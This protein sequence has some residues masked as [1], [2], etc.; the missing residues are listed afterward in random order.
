M[1]ADAF[2][3][4]WVQR[5]G[6][7]RRVLTDRGANFIKALEKGCATVIGCRHIQTSPYHPEGNGTCEAF[8]KYL[9]QTLPKIIASHPNLRLEIAY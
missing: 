3:N 6:V 4:T 1:I 2:I 8:N 7:P 9:K 5:Y